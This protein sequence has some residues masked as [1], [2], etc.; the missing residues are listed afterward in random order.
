MFI[1]DAV[2]FI[3]S[4]ACGDVVFIP[5]LPLVSIPSLSRSA[6]WSYI[7]KRLVSFEAEPNILHVP[8]P[9]PLLFNQMSA[10]PPS[11]FN[12]VLVDPDIWSLADDD[13]IV[14]Q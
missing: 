5:T 10:S 12:W 6:S 2:D 8:A 1:F 7:L 3:S 4:L 9:P 14:P 13:V 11:T